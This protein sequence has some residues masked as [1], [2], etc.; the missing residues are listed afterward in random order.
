MIPVDHI[1]KM[2]ESD[3]N[4]N[5][6]LSIEKQLI[7]QEENARIREEKIYTSQSRTV[8]ETSNCVNMSR[9]W[10]K[11]KILSPHKEQ[12]SDLW[13]LR[14]TTEPLRLYGER[15][16]LRSSCLYQ[17][18]RKMWESDIY[19]NSKLFIDEQLIAQEENARI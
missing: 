15:G 6:K 7:A 16:L 3:M 4:T 1:L 14:S 8:V 9:A 11:E 12:N 5:S 17:N 19:I 18:K 13:I 10:D 2:W